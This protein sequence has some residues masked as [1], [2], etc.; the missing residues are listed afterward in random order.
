MTYLHRFNPRPIFLAC[1]LVLPSVTSVPAASAAP[2][3]QA[4]K[5]TE[6]AMDARFRAIYEREWKW[7]QEQNGSSGEEDSPSARMRLPDV[8]PEAYAARLKV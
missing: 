4:V 2:V 6:S 5:P 8:S 3:T 7:R 1:L